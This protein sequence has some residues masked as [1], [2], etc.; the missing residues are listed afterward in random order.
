MTCNFPII[1]VI[2]LPKFSEEYLLSNLAKLPQ[3]VN[4][5]INVPHQEVLNDGLKNH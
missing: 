5:L 2:E 3:L 1:R 4:K